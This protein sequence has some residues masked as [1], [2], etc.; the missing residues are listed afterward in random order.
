MLI[1]RSAQCGSRDRHGSDRVTLAELRDDL[2]RPPEAADRHRQRLLDLAEK[3]ARIQALG[4][5][6]S[7]V[8]LSEYASVIA[9][10]HV[11]AA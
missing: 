9:T 10:G 6:Y 8:G 2:A 1:P 7:R 5:E 4:D 3:V 11:G